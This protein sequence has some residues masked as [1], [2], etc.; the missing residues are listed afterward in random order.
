[1]TGYEKRDIRFSAIMIAFGGLAVLLGGVAL[2]SSAALRAFSAHF[3]AAARR[4][5]PPPEP[6]LQADAVA[7]LRRQRAEEAAVLSSCAWLDR[8]RGVIRLPI[9]RAMALLLRRGLPT[10]SAS[11]RPRS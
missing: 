7:D 9:E 5:L 3:S 11:P 6:R 4:R 10:R 1:M 2:S 8:P